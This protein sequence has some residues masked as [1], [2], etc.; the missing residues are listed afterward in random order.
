VKPKTGYMECGLSIKNYSVY[1]I[2]K[3]S[4]VFICSIKML[5]SEREIKSN[6]I[7]WINF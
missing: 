5:N 4:G 3:I 2:Q 7:I 6:N 1:I